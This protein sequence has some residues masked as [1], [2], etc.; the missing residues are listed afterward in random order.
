MLMKLKMAGVG[1]LAGLAI[2]VAGI[3]GLLTAA[4]LL[5]LVLAM[6]GMGPGHVP[7][8]SKLQLMTSGLMQFFLVAAA[9]F[10]VAYGFILNP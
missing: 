6:F 3:S 1:A 10:A 4:S 8:Q 5:F 2:P 7:Y 9:T